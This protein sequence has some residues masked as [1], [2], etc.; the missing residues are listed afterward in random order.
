[1]SL[2]S[3]IKTNR[4]NVP[5]LFAILVFV[6]LALPVPPHF[7]ARISAVGPS[8]VWAGSP[9]ETLKPPSNPP[10][11]RRLTLP[12]GNTQSITGRALPGRALLSV[13]WRVY[14][15]TVRL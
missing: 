8:V 4:A 13:L 11:A 2:L 3:S 15:T 7:Q 5:F 6:F 12:T 10:R 14:W 1:M 9:D